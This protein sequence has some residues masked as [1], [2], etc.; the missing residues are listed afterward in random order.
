[1]AKNDDAKP[2]DTPEAEHPDEGK[3]GQESSTND[4]ERTK[5]ITKRLL[6]CLGVLYLISACILAGFMTSE[7]PVLVAI[8]VFAFGVLGAFMSIQRRLRSLPAED[9]ELLATSWCFVCLS[10]FA[11]GTL[12]IVLYIL[13]I[14]GIVSGELFPSFVEGDKKASGF[15]RLLKCRAAGYDDYAKLIVWAFIA[16]FSESFVTNILGSLSRQAQDRTEK[17]DRAPGS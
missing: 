12:A 16:G 4:L 15:E 11:G 10:P 3:S 5:Q 7:T 6:L 9:Q 14:S 17:G 1:M 13:F 2:A 8:V